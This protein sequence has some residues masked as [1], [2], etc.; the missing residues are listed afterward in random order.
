MPN[1]RIVLHGEL[2]DIAIPDFV[3][4]VHCVRDAVRLLEV[5][6]PR[7]K[8][9]MCNAHEN[10]IAFSVKVLDPEKEYLEKCWELETEEL[11]DPT[12]GKEI[13]IS[14]VLMGSGNIGKI[15]LGV[16][17]IGLSFS[18]I[19]LLGLSPLMT[20]LMGGLLILQGVMGGKP[21]APD[22][23]EENTKSFVFSG[24]VN[25]VSS[26]TRV[27]ILFGYEH[28]IGSIVISAN[29]RTFDIRQ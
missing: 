21:P 2:A 1:T 15:I 9:Y 13:H 14:P 8:P 5:N 6:F 17:L 20:G 27:P 26:G 11:F 19:G 23:N 7:F 3:A 24:A 10:G 16:A 25:T 18:G 22:P 4:N 28:T 12:Q 29:I